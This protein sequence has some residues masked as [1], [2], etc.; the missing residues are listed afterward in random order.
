[1]QANIY[2]FKNTNKFRKSVKILIIIM[3]SLFLKQYEKDLHEFIGEELS[4]LFNEDSIIEDLKYRKDPL[5][6]F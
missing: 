4:R 1:M 3:N 6:Y 2:I 5:I